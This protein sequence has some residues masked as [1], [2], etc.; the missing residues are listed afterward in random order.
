MDNNYNTLFD[1]DLAEYEHIIRQPV[2][3]P[4]VC[5]ECEACGKNTDRCKEI[6][7]GWRCPIYER[8]H[9]RP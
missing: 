9:D 5:A 1:S 8:S 6:K 3:S 2:K 4:E 7:D